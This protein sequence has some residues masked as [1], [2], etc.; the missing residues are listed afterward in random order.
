VSNGAN[1]VLAKAAHSDDDDE[2]DRESGDDDDEDDDDD[3]MSVAR[4]DDVP[5]DE[6]VDAYDELLLYDELKL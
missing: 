4:G 2:S 6:G 5:D 3:D 1:V